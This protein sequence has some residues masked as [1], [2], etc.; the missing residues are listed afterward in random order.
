MKA[1]FTACLLL[2]CLQ[3]MAQGYTLE[4]SQINL[5]DAIRFKA[6][7]AELTQEDRKTLTA[8]RDFLNE[9]TYVS[10][11]RIEAHVSGVASDVQ[12]LS[13]KRA[14]AISRWLTGEG[15]D[16]KRI[17]AVGFG[18]TKPAD[19]K[20]RVTFV[21]AAL[22]NRLIGGMPADGGGKV[23]GDPCKRN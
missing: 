9:K 1:I 22:R 4:G 11:L 16:C 15:I 18:D 8:I 21:I 7:T 3:G 20:T 12:Q 19:Q 23:A 5:A 2:C 13:E 14:M 10:I 6:G 17:I